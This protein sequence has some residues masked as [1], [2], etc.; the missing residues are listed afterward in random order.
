MSNSYTGELVGIQIALEFLSEIDHSDL[1]NSSIYLFTDCQLAFITVFD[2]KP[3]MSKIEIVT[4]IKE[5]CNALYSKRNAFVRRVPGHWGIRGNELAHK[6]AKV[7]AA[8]VSGK[9]DIPIEMDKK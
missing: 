2:K 5:C 6:L 8:E 7:A 3:P 9:E 4:K 1:V